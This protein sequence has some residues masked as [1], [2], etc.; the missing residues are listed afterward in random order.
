MG[1]TAYGLLAL[2]IVVQMVVSIFGSYAG[3]SVD[4]VVQGGSV[5]AA[6]GFLGVVT[7]AWESIKFLFSMVTF[8]VDG[9]PLFMSGIFLVMSLMTV[10]IIVRT[11]RGNA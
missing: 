9:M 7:W 10:F 5:A 8:Q 4:G 11:I 3:Y 2:L 1:I 6:P